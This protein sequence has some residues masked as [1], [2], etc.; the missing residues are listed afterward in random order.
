MID[1]KTQMEQASKT[2]QEWYMDVFRPYKQEDRE[3]CAVNIAAKKIAAG[4]KE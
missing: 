3:R 2:A 1:A 4:L